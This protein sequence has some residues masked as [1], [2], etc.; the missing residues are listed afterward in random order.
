MWGAGSYRSPETAASAAASRAAS[1]PARPRRPLVTSA[2]RQRRPRCAPANTSPADDLPCARHPLP[3]PA[4][5]YLLTRALPRAPAG[6]A[7]GRSAASRWTTSSRP[8]L[9]GPTGSASNHAVRHLRQRPVRHHRARQLHARAVRRV[10][11]HVRPRER[12]PH[13]GDRRGA[14]TGARR[15]VVVNPMLACRAARHRAVPRVR[16]GEYGLCRNTR[17][18]PGN[19]PMIGYCPASAAAGPAPSSRTARSCTRSG[20]LTTK[21]PCWPTRSRPR[22]GPCCCTRRG[23][24]RGAGHRRR[25]HRRSDRPALRATGWEGPSPVSDATTSS[26]SW[27][28]RRRRPPCSAGR[29]GLRW[30]ENRCRRARV[31][32]DARAALRRGRA[33]A[34]LR[35][36]RQ[37]VTIRTRSPSPARA[38]ASCWWAPRRGHGRLDPVWYRQLTIAGIFAYGRA[39][40]GRAD[41]DIYD[42][43]I[44]LLR[45]RR[46]R[47]A[48]HGDPRFRTG[49]VSCSTRSRPRQGRTPFHQGRLPARP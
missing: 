48:R 30:A 43:S 36:G 11:V 26:S 14:A 46:R 31:Q 2:S 24:R 27:P 4:R 18:A 38:A 19:G 15:R 1:D 40:F 8:P 16:R 17:T 10:P 34:G 29:R 22:C 37:R 45:D 35:H 33:V 47:A 21:W 44:E 3:L 7:L 42:S 32:A 5:R 41:R 13:R 23:R 9:P 6:L 25:H 12:R 20:R 28:R 49:G 39:P